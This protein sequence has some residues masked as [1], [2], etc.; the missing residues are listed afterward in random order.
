M[1]KSK[2]YKIWEKALKVIPDGNMLL[3]K[4]PDIFLPYGWPTYFNKAYGYKICD[5]SNQIYS[6]FSYMG[7]GTNI[8][9]YANKQIDNHVINKI[10]NG[11]IST[12]NSREDLILAEK[13]LE[14]NSWAQMVKFTRTGGE[15]ASVAIR[16]ARAVSQK[17][18]VIVCGY[19]G[20]H[21]W[22][23]S[24]NLK[25]S[26]NLDKHLFEKTRIDGVPKELNETTYQFQYNDINSAKELIK[27]DKKIGTIIMEVKRN[28]DPKDNFLKKIRK[29]CDEKNIVLIFDECTSG[30]RESY[31]GIHKNYAVFPDICIYGKALGNGYPINAIVGKKNIMENASNSFISSTFWTEGLGPTA[32]IKT[33]EVFKKE[34]SWKY[35]IH[36]GQKIKES[37]QDLSN[38][39]NIKLE[40]SGLDAIPVFNFKNANHQKYKTYLTQCMLEEGILASNAIYIST[41]HD[42]L[43][44]NKYFKILDKIFKNISNCINEK[45]NIDNLLKYPVSSL[46]LRERKSNG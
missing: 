2:G 41:K 21:D 32:A 29:L 15:A 4:R 22:Y 46:T 25:D 30:F 10:R 35:L 39:H 33:L 28:I 34:K 20:W 23:L 3:S 13:L 45:E 1:K 8:L 17:S 19:H 44:F 9:G 36:Y 12:L 37:W 26:S 43:I 16:I 31:G 18:K 24:T 5:L 27:K 40:I 6:D 11:S 14:I 42:K 7:V 38:T